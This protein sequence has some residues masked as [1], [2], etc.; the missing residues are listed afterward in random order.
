M[1]KKIELRLTKEEH[2]LITAI[3][4]MHHTG[5]VIQIHKSHRPLLNKVAMDFSLRDI[6]LSIE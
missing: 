5:L 4:I 6:R 3:L 1:C 2:Q